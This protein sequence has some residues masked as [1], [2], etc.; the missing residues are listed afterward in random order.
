MKRPNK[1]V[2]F[3][4][5]HLQRK[6][7]LVVLLLVIPVMGGMSAYWATTQRQ[8]ASAELALRAER[9]ASLL[10]QTLAPPLWNLDEGVL[11]AQLDA[12][13]ADPDLFSIGVY[14]QSRAV[15]VVSGQ[16]EGEP[17]DGIE[18]EALIIYARDLDRITLGAVQ[19]VYTHEYIYQDIA[20]TQY[21]IS[22]FIL[23]LSA[24]LAIGLYIVIRQ[25]VEKPIHQMSA[26]MAAVAEG[27]F[28]AKVE[29][30]SRDEIGQLAQSLNWMTEKLQTSYVDLQTLNQELEARVTARVERLKT[31]ASLSEEL[32]AILDLEELLPH[33][34]EVIQERFGLYYAGVFLIDAAGQWAVLRAGS[35]A[36]GRAMLAAEHRL[37]VGGQSMIGAAIS[38]ERARI[39][40]DVGEEAVR[41]SNPH[42]PDTHS[43][44]ALPLI[45]R[46]GVIGAMTIQSTQSQAFSVEDITELQTVA[47]QVAVAIDNARL[48]AE[49]QVALEEIEAVQRRYLGRAWGEY[50]QGKSFS[51][52][53]QTREGAIP[54]TAT[55]LP[56]VA[57]IIEQGG[58]RLVEP[59]F[60]GTTQLVVPIKF[61]DQ[62]IGAVGIK[63]ET[64]RAWTED[65]IALAEAIAEQLALAAENL[66]LLD[67]TQ[68][69]AAREQLTREITD[70]MRRATNMEG[71]IQTAV[72]EMAAAL[73]V[74]DTFVQLKSPET[75]SKSGLQPATAQGAEPFPARNV[76]QSTPDNG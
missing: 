33:V 54:L 61:R 73:G 43:E 8:A 39:A 52:Y 21:V 63:E 5:T 26:T 30:R 70:K 20:R 53:R 58:R 37:E 9:M 14:E 38:T 23:A 2:D 47:N 67:A 65:D 75:D 42:L 45:S 74:R 29:L 71:L 28:S 62:A 17:V 68:R 48:F 41:F 12:V 66:R 51:G 50:M 15:P 76:G 60:E 6:L 22:A 49:S 16:R 59:D 56:E 40:L 57:R 7:M 32:N 3:F 24:V 27:E 18:R 13:L 19:L 72:L 10:S 55:I 25:L 11:R 31:I 35:G 4:A 69:R 46:G 36:A 44:M 1:L 64:T 34:V